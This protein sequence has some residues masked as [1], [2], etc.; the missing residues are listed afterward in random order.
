M[1]APHGQSF[2][3]KRSWPDSLRQAPTGKIPQG[4]KLAKKPRRIG[5]QLPAAVPTQDYQ[6]T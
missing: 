1:I 3:P 2:T 6:F 5:Q 4:A